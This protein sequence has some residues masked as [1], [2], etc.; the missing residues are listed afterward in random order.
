MQGFYEIFNYQA[1]FSEVGDITGYKYVSVGTWVSGNLNQPLSLSNVQFGLKPDGS[2]RTKP[3][4]SQCGTCSPGTYIRVIIGSC[5]GVCE[6]C[7]GKN[8][9]SQPNAKQCDSCL[10]KGKREMWGNS[11]FTGSNNCVL[12]PEV[13]AMYE[14]V[15]A[16]I[17]LILA[18]AGLLCV[19][20]TAIIFGRY[21]KTPIVKSS[22]REQMV[23]LLTGI[24][25]SFV[26]PFFYVAPPSIPICLVNRLGI[27]FC[28]SLM[29]GAL[30]IKAQRVARIF[31]GVK[32]NLHYTP[33]FSSPIYQVIFTMVIVAIQ[34]VVVIFSLAF[35]HPDIQRVLRYDRDDEG[36]FGLPEV[37]VVC[38]KENTATIAISLFYETFVI[39]IA[40]ILGIFS[41]KFPK[42]F[43]EAKYISFCTFSL[44]VVWLGLVPAY[45]TTE[46]RP[47]IQNAV[48]SIFIFLS[49][50]GVL[51]FIFGPKLF[52]ALFRSE[53][54]T[55]TT[56]QYK[57]TQPKQRTQTTAR[58]ET[59]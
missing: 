9:S 54:N 32:R 44:L 47:E 2:L 13:S 42:N 39:V 37:V 41:F 1:T 12:I 14:N 57:G 38:R 29:F 20:I 24:S 56:N 40:T 4:E 11:P 53:K 7:L 52:I 3:V 43:N 21:W 17:S 30:V 19:I 10:V 31:Y 22:S 6:P 36:N 27:W 48:I 26:L 45:F 49:G 18:C 35:V 50:F 34:M 16:I 25:C 33:R 55:F 23:L 28:Y 59:E 15:L 51:C 8:F 5:C 58:S 46:S